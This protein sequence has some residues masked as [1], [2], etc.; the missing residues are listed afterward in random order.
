MAAPTG[1]PTYIV[2][3]DLFDDDEA[4]TDA[5]PAEPV[6]ADAEPEE[7][8]KPAR[9]APKQAAEEPEEEDEPA[10]EPPVEPPSDPS[11][12]LLQERMRSV[13]LERRL[14]DIEARTRPNP[15]DEDAAAER[16]IEERRKAA[17]QKAMQAVRDGDDIARQE[18]MWE[19]EDVQREQYRR[20]SERSLREVRAQREP[21]QNA[22]H[23]ARLTQ[24]QA[25][26]ME[27]GWFRQQYRVTPQEESK[28]RAKWSTF[29]Q[30]NPA[31]AGPHVRHWDRL[32]MAL[33]LVRGRP[34]A[35]NIVTGGQYSAAPARSGPAKM[36]LKDR[37]A[38]AKRHGVSLEEYDKIMGAYLKS[39][40]RSS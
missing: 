6:K 13:E 23:Q 27:E 18:A 14:A 26:E 19:L 11:Y 21:T 30:A 37:Q 40:G 12:L 35:Q 39:Q 38:G 22:Q 29:V 3:D 10:P 16:A 17:R 15:Q 20:D 31:W 8:T 1:T 25:L 4:E 2:P 36:P 34:P 7:P 28:M 5:A 24:Q 9:P 33:K 32:D